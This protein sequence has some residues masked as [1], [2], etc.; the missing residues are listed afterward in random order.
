MRKNN[1]GST[2]NT[3][4]NSENLLKR[5]SSENNN[6]N[7]ENKSNN[8][9]NVIEHSNI[10]DNK[11]TSIKHNK[12]AIDKLIQSNEQHL[13]IKNTNYIPKILLPTSNDNSSKCINNKNKDMPKPAKLNNNAR[14]ESSKIV[15]KDDK[16]NLKN[17]NNE[18]KE[19][20]IKP[21]I[22]RK[23]TNKEKINV[24]EKIWECDFCKHLNQHPIN[25]CSNCKEPNKQTEQKQG[26]SPIKK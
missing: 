23:N 8:T 20:R 13:K 15:E 7:I 12:N 26:S 22:E 24:L 9:S 25:K 17:D 1:N 21:Y 19:D 5:R 11:I 10:Y 16:T 6:N 18:I 3:S 14:E 4:M 2:N